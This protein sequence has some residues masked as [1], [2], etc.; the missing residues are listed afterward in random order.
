VNP[1]HAVLSTL[2]SSPSTSGT[3][4]AVS[5]AA[6]AVVDPDRPTARRWAVEELTDPAYVQA[7][8][9]LLARALMWALEQLGELL[10]RAG[11]AGTP[12]GLVV[13]VVVVAVVVLLALLLA[14]PLRRSGRT[15]A[16]GGGVFTSVLRTATEHRAEAERAARSGR[17]DV[18]VQERFR[19][20]ARSLEERVVLDARPGRTADEVAREA[21]TVL[22]GT[23][24]A[25]L[26]AARAFDDVTYGERPGSEAGYRLC[27]E[28][29][30]LVGAA[31]PGRLRTGATAGT[32]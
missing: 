31:R 26:R 28:A 7:Q 12:A 16:R 14:G 18:A 24:E 27:V 19:A 2:L 6:R 29:D 5:R 22:T 8:P 1:A 13:G 21:G 25:L 11:G 3:S 4:S 23:G 30:D 15:A 20:L 17:W 32:P 9:G 10:D